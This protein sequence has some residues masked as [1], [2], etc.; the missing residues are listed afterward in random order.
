MKEEIRRCVGESVEALMAGIDVSLI[1]ASG[2]SSVAE[3]VSH[4]ARHGIKEAE[5]KLFIEEA[6]GQITSAILSEAEVLGL[7]LTGGASGLMVCQKLGADR[8]S[9]VEEIAPGI[10]LLRLSTG[11]PAVTKAGGFGVDDSLI[12]ATQRMRRLMS[13]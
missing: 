4:A 3:F 9:I 8:A 6:L 13:N 7:L 10:P 11:M 1:T 2:E 5:A 12:Q